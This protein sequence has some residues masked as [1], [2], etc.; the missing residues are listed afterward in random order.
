M[1]NVNVALM[2]PSEWRQIIGIELHG[3]EEDRV[4]HIQPGS[5]NCRPTVGYFTA[6]FQEWLL[7]KAEAIIFKNML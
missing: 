4:A 6:S 5:I 1:M 3:I 7:S 2:R